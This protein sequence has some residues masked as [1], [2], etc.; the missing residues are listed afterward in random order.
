MTDS[1]HRRLIELWK[2]A[3]TSDTNP[4]KWEIHLSPYQFYALQ[5]DDEP[6][7]DGSMDYNFYR[8]RRPGGPLEPTWRG[9]FV[10]TEQLPVPDFTRMEEIP[11][12]R[13]ISDG[14]LRLVSITVVL[15]S[16]RVV[17]IDD[18]DNDPYWTAGG[19]RK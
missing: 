17:W 13:H 2:R 14:D 9:L 8:E 6:R 4:R 19:P 12:S 1:P 15:E 5:R 7:R 11:G 16:G 18:A 3:R 10:T